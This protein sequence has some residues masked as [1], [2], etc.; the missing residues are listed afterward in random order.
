MVGKTLHPIL[1]LVCTTLVCR[2]I[3][4]CLIIRSRVGMTKWCQPDQRVRWHWKVLLLHRL[5]LV[6]LRLWLRLLW[7]QLLLLR[8]RLLAAAV[9][10]AAAHLDLPVRPVKANHQGWPARPVLS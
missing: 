3:P 7:Q 5:L 1:C 6:L 9:A 10:V 8:V 2:G 4:P